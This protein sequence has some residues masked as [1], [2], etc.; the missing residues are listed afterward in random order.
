MAGDNDVTILLDEALKFEPIE[1]T[2]EGNGMERL[3][4]S[5]PVL[6]GQ[7]IWEDL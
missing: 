1:T 3:S 5:S 6:R 4:L 2:D 7:S